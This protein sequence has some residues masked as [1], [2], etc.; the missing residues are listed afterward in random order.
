[1]RKKKIKKY[2]RRQKKVEKTHSNQYLL[3][4]NN[5]ITYVYKTD[6]KKEIIEIVCVSLDIRIE[7]KW[8]TIIYYDNHHG[9]LHRHS[10]IAYNDEADITDSNRVKRRGGNNQL[11]QWAIKDIKTNYIN[12]KKKFIKRNRLILDAVEIDIY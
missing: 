2:F 9:S 5:R 12:Y 4:Q 1:M 6:S 11:L 8:I 7:E 10:R 3:S